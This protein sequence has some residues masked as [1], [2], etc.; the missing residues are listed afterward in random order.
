MAWRRAVFEFAD[1]SQTNGHTIQGPGLNPGETLTRIRMSWVAYH[2]ATSP[3]DGV[4]FSIAF[5]AI[6]LP[7]PSTAADVP[8]PFDLPNADWVWWESG[9]M[10]PKTLMSNQTNLVN[11]I[12]VSPPDA[13]RER[14][15]RAQRLADPVNGSTVWFRTQSS[16]FSPGQ[17]THWLSLSYSV[18]VLLPP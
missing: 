10:T 18:G 11:E 14:D 15:V 3:A 5:G 2:T 4:G 1:V 16:T 6:V 12:D 9:F 17:S 8:G 7:D 13:G